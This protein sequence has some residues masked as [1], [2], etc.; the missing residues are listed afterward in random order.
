MGRHRFVYLFSCVFV[1]LIV[2]VFEFERMQVGL[3]RFVF[4]DK[5]LGAAEAFLAAGNQGMRS[6]I[7]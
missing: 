7:D 1:F 5:K 6:T 3:G 4:S 2:F